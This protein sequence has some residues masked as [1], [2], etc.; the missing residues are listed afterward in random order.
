MW[1]TCQLIMLSANMKAK[2][3]EYAIMLNSTTG[4]NP[5]LSHGIIQREQGFN[6]T[7]ENQHLY[8]V[9]DDKIEEGDWFIRFADGSISPFIK[10]ANNLTVEINNWQL[11]KKGSFLNKKIIATTDGG[12]NFP[13]IP[14]SFIENF[15]KEYNIGNVIKEVLVEYESYP[16]YLTI[17][18]E[19]NAINRDGS[20]N[21][22]GENRDFRIILKG[23]NN[24]N[25][26][27]PKTSWN[28]EEIIALINKYEKDT[29]PLR[30]EGYPTEQK[31]IDMWIKNNL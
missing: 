18:A 11:N 3:G 23:N 1:K 6:I 8:I 2:V 22:G 7:C 17:L 4:I 26:Q 31:D 9:S 16:G 30:Y 15:V 5:Y 21:W 12:L 10:K 14:I 20:L 28:K 19:I 24:V 25:I 29:F 27:L 13:K